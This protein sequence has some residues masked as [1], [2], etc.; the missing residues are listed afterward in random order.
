MCVD[1]CTFYFSLGLPTSIA[2]YQLD[3]K[4]IEDLLSQCPTVF[5]NVI[6]GS[7][8]LATHLH[9]FAC[10]HFCYFNAGGRGGGGGGR[11]ITSRRKS[12]EERLTWCIAYI[13]NSN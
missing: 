1:Q 10:C 3:Q 2:T 13:K 12:T 9:H 11:L 7:S 8:V 4:K 5:T 6:E